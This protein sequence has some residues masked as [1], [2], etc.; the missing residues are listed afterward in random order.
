MTDVGRAAP[1]AGAAHEPGAAD[2]GLA[3]RLRAGDPEALR[4]LYDRHAGLVHALA[5]RA[6]GTRHDADDLT[7]QVFVRAWRSRATFDP[8]RGAAGAWLV[9]ITRRQ[10]ADRFAGLARERALAE[11]TAGPAPPPGAVSDQVVDAVAVADEMNRL[12]PEQRTVVRLA[13]F[14]DLTHQQIAALTGLPLGTVKSHLR[15]GLERMRRR[16]EEIDGAAPG[17]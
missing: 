1:R 4:E 2:T 5:L 15:R 9:G 6:L 13:F 16:W 11:R 12:P 10:I 7:Q 8:T 3:V 14:D 17:S